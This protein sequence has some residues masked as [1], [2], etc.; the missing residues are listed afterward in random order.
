MN[1]RIFSA[2]NIMRVK[3]CD[4][5]WIGLFAYVTEEFG[6]IGKNVDEKTVKELEKFFDIPFYKVTVF[7]TNLVGVFITGNG[8]KL[9][10]PEIEEEEKKELERVT[11]VVVLNSK[12]NA[13]G[14]NIVFAENAILVNPE[15]EERI[16]DLPE[17][18]FKKPVYDI[19]IGG[20]NIIGQLMV[21]FK[22]RVLVGNIATKKDIEKIKKIL[23]PE[24]INVCSVNFGSPFLKAGMLVNSKGILVG[25]DTT[26]PEIAVIEETLE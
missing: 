5:K 14:N 21:V 11:D 25:W 4:I 24:K 3:K 7:G 12:L 19:K 16:K 10:V 23:N 15:M 8:K 9:V 13:L 18:E 22:N 20:L 2:F 1:L 26:G 17:K 6:L